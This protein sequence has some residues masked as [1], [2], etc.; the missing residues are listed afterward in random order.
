MH[1][2][3]WYSY[4]AEDDEE[5]QKPNGHARPRMNSD[6]RDGGKRRRASIFEGSP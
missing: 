6:E 4:T 2:V 1:I 5:G 3:E